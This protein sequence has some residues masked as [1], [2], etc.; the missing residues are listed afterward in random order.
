MEVPKIIDM[1]MGG[2]AYVVETDGGETKSLVSY[3]EVLAVY[4]KNKVG[5]SATASMMWRTQDFA[6][7]TSL[8]HYEAFTKWLGDYENRGYLTLKK[9]EVQ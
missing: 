1:R 7:V 5:A 6:T 8:K 3:G 2:K 4:A 9:M